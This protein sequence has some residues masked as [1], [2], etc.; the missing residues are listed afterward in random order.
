VERLA[1]HLPL[2]NNLV[3][4]AKRPLVDIVDDPRSTQTTLTERVVHC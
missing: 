2:M 4:P 3:H 1:V